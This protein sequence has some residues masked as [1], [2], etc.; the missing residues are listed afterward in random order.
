MHQFRLA[1]GRVAPA[2]LH[3]AGLEITGV[4]ARADLAVGVLRGQPDFQVVGLDGR[5]AHV[6]GAQQH[7]AVRQAQLF[8]HHFRTAGHAGVLGVAVFR[9]ADRHQLDLLELVLA[10]HAAHV[11]AAAAS[12]GTEAHRVGGHA[13]RQ[14]L[15]VD[16]LVT[17]QVGQRHFRG[18]DQVARGIA[19]G[20]LEQV[21]LELRQLAGA[22]QRIGVDQQRHVGFFVAVFA[23]VQVQHE[24]GQGTV[25]AGDL[26]AQHGEARARQLGGGL[27]VQAAVAGAQLDVV[28]HREIEGAR[29]A[30][31]RLLDVVVLVG[32][33]R[34][35][36]GRQVR[37]AGG[38]GVDLL[39]QLVQGHFRGLQLVGE[40]GH[41]GHDGRHV[42]AL[43][44][45]LADGLGT[46]VAQ[47][48]QFLGP[49]LDA[50][51]IGLQGLQGRHVELEAA[52][53]A[54]AFGEVGGLVA[55]QGWIKHGGCRGGYQEWDYRLLYGFLP[56][57]SF[58][59]W[60][61]RDIPCWS[62]P[63]LHPTHRLPSRSP[64]I[65]RATP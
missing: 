58:P 31:A 60:Q 9:A 48:L 25:Q 7:L 2:G 40:G 56:P 8:Q 55:E 16:D 17:H 36:I 26:A 18:R 52:A 37:D 6:A 51:A 46:A 28:Q 30:P 39:A 38:D 20:G 1:G 61:N 15:G 19:H 29:G 22:T 13:Q 63:C 42:L 53:G 14:A 65:S 5:E 43:G 4:G 64:C 49:H 62:G 3:A 27:G 35:V 10:D 44:L 54:Q 24:L 41:F 50:L 45:G 23:G 12:F 32:A 57:G 11:T 59:P 21:V 47:A 33:G 34:H